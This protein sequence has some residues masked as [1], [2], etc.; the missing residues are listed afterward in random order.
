VR[1]AR[2][3]AAAVSAALVVCQS[4]ASATPAVSFRVFTDTGIRLTDVVWTGKQFLYVENTKNEVYAAPPRGAPKTLFASMPD[5]VEETRCRLSP[6]A[7]GF[8]AGDIFCHSPD[9]KI[10]RISADGKTVDVFATLPNKS[11]SDGAMAFDDVGRFGYDLVVATGRSGAATPSG[12]T[13][14]TVSAAGAVRAIGGYHGP[15]GTDQALIAPKSLGALRGEL[16]LAVDPGPKGTIVAMDPK[17]RTRVVAHLNDGPNPIVIVTQA[18]KKPTGDVTPGL[19]V[20]DTLSHKVF[21]A[22]AAALAPYV[23]DVVIGSE[24][25]GLFWALRPKG[26]G[27]EAAPIR[28]NLGG[29]KYNFEGAAYVAG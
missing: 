2:T 3:F 13:V 8:P 24:L 14:Y 7:H 29:H 15:G 9:N 18:A 11:I 26:N 22:P 28:T 1:L 21:F 4:A 16:L 27:F 25:E 6:G 23:G 19:Y 17:G 5:V 10:Y 12:G 20:T